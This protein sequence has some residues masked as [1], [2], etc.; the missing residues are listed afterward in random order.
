MFFQNWYTVMQEFEEYRNG[1]LKAEA[2]S[3][4]D[5]ALEIWEKRTREAKREEWGTFQVYDEFGSI[6]FRGDRA[7]ENLEG[8]L[9]ELLQKEGYPIK[10]CINQIY[11][12]LPIYPYK[13]P[14]PTYEVVVLDNCRSEAQD[15]MTDW[16]IEHRNELL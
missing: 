15:Y 13:V 12:S 2:P 11:M 5:R 9:N 8:N 7:I 3:I 4:F 10:V 16:I 14:T 1:L 6:Y